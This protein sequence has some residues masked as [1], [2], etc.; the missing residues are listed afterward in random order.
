MSTFDWICGITLGSKFCLV[1]SSNIEIAIHQVVYPNLFGSAHPPT[2]W[3]VCWSLLGY[4]WT[5]HLGE[6]TRYLVPLV[7][8]PVLSA[9]VSV[10]P[11]SWSTVVLHLG[12]DIVWCVVCL[13]SLCYTEG[14]FPRSF[15]LF[16]A[17]FFCVQIVWWFALIPI[18]VC[19]L[20]LPALPFPWLVGRVLWGLKISWAFFMPLCL[21]R[22]SI[23]RFPDVLFWVLCCPLPC[24]CQM[25]GF[26]W[27]LIFRWPL[28]LQCDAIFGKEVHF[29]VEPCCSW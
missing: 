5:M 3:K 6:L 22:G 11:G 13:P 27:K 21:G 16:V 2:V 1:G 25:P 23:E 24:Y 18:F 28:V 9:I 19:V 4:L 10:C 20:A 15:V 7:L 29:Y 14:I 26:V 17:Y 8:C 12:L